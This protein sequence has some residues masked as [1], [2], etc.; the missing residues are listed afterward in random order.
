MAIYD[1]FQ[2]FNE[3]HMLDLRMNILKDDIDYFVISEST[4][5]HQG[6][7]KKLNFDIKNFKKFEHKIIYTVANFDEEKK[8]INH[9]GG[10]SIIEQ[11]QR[12]NI[13][14]ESKLVVSIEA[15]EIDYWKKYTGKSGLNFGINSFG[16][17]APYK[18]IFDHFELNIQNISKRIKEKL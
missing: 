9:K 4:K 8:F 10:E 1:C 17:S 13:L 7:S 5:N 15:S 11:H 16:K 6:S 3:D 12:N 18:K 2:Y 14:N